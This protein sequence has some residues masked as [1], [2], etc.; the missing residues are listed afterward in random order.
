[1]ILPAALFL[2]LTVPQTPAPAKAHH[3]TT[4]AAAKQPSA[5]KGPK[6]EAELQADLTAALRGEGFEGDAI[7]PSIE[8]QEITLRGDVH[9]AE[10]KGLA[11]R[12]ARKV[13][14]KDG[15]KDARV[16]NQIAVEL[17]K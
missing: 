3:H 12:V 16:L 5:A 10:H 7:A 15:W 2:L 6:S 11:T 4:V 17:R 14:E 9:S 13:A 8:K 1:M